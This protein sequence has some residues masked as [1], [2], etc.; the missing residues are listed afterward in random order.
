MIKQ[1][2]NQN[3][4]VWPSNSS[5]VVDHSTTDPEVKGSNPATAWHIDKQQSKQVWPINSTIVVEHSTTDPEG[6]GSNPA[7]AWH[8][9]KMEE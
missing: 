7:T 9:D 2:S 5:I 8:N 1:Q 3:R 6:K 4:L